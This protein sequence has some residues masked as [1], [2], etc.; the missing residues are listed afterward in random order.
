[1]LRAPLSIIHH[2]LRRRR[3]QHHIKPLEQCL[4]HPHHTFPNG[5]D[6]LFLSLLELNRFSLLPIIPQ[7]DHHPNQTSPTMI[8]LHPSLSSDN[9]ALEDKDL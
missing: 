5:L 9:H 2:P 6:R 1:V 7:A 3:R 4:S 8:S